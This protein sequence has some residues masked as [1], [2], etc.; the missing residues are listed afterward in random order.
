MPQG[1]GDQAGAES[2]HAHGP[3]R[4]EHR[5]FRTDR[6]EHPADQALAGHPEQCAETGLEGRLGARAD[7]EPDQDLPRLRVRAQQ[8]ADGRVLE[9]LAPLELVE[10]LGMLVVSTPP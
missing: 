1:V 6:P 7:L 8:P 9:P 3:D 10:G 5:L 4:I 2:R